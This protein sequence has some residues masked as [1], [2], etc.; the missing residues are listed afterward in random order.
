MTDFLRGAQSF[1]REQ[2]TP[3]I[4]DATFGICKLGFTGFIRTAWFRRAVGEGAA[5]KLPNRKISNPLI[6]KNY[7]CQRCDASR[8]ESAIL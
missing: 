2:L 3:W 8:A 1:V 5:L 4:G 7:P 6:F